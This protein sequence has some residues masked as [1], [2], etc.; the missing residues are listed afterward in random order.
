[1]V[2]SHQV[3]SHNFHTLCERLQQGSPEFTD[4]QWIKTSKPVMCPLRN[5]TIFKHC[6]VVSPLFSWTCKV[7]LEKRTKKKKKKRE[8]ASHQWWF[9]FPSALLEAQDVELHLRPLRRHIQC[10][11]ETEFPH[12]RVLIAPL[13]HTICLI[14][15]HS[16]FYNT[17]ARIIVLLQE[18][19]NLF[20]DQVCSIQN[21]D[22]KDHYHVVGFILLDQ[23]RM[24][25]SRLQSEHN[26]SFFFFRED[27]CTNKVQVFF[28]FSS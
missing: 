9:S 7:N 25:K 13:F 24:S 5:R 21:R 19:C 3:F 23:W 28:Y 4:G 26:L 18:F 1:M 10:L 15:S 14:W 12:T 11:Q 17:P 22:T 8:T 20:V 6:H 16:K 2:Y 27:F